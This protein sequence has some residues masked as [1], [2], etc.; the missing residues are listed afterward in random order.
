MEKRVHVLSKEVRDLNDMK[1][2]L[3]KE[4]VLVKET[5]QIKEREIKASHDLLNNE[6]DRE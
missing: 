6:R 3:E 5:A 1:S 2:K 4:N